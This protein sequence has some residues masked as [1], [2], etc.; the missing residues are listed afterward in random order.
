[1]IIGAIFSLFTLF[2]ACY[3]L[4]NVF[5]KRQ[6]FSFYDETLKEETMRFNIFSK[7]FTPV[8]KIKMPAMNGPAARLSM[9]G[10]IFLLI[11]VFVGRACDGCFKP[12][13]PVVD[14]VYQEVA[15]YNPHVTVINYP[16]RKG[17]DLELQH[18]YDYAI[19]SFVIDTAVLNNIDGAKFAADTTYRNEII[20]N[21]VV[22]Q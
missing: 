1:M 2:G 22:F 16:I 17:I 12:G 19:R 4:V 7:Q 8:P 3:W 21:I 14:E 5:H 20:E 13:E 18:V 9:V 15:S 10:G 11:L 6:Y